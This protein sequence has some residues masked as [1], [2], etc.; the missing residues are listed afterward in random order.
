MVERRGALIALCVTACSSSSGSGNSGPV[1]GAVG[2]QSFTVVDATGIAGELTVSGETAN[3]TDVVLTS[4]TGA[5]SSLTADST[6][7]SSVTVFLAVAAAGPVGPGTYSISSAG[8]ARAVF[9]S[10]DAICQVT[11]QD[12]AESGTI[13]YET[14]TSSSITGSV[15][16]QF[17]SGAL[18]G[19]FTASVC[20]VSLSTVVGYTTMT[21]TCQQ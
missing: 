3:E 18:Q 21:G 20:G 6:P 13:T 1:K 11:T 4:W 2:G 5:C 7:P 16:A 19:T 14:V 15:D 10:E 12:V 8:A 9:A 17:A